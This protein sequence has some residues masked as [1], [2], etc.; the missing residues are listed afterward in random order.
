M[1]FPSGGPFLEFNFYWAALAEEEAFV[2]LVATLLA[3]GA[4]FRRSDIDTMED[5]EHA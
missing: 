5:L 3:L 1:R 4:V 2:R